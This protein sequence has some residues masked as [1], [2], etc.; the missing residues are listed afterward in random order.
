[1]L[2]FYVFFMNYDWGIDQLVHVSILFMI[3]RGPDQ[4]GSHG[5][6]SFMYYFNVRILII[7][8]ETLICSP[9]RV[10]TFYIFM[11]LMNY[12]WCSYWLVHILILFI[13]MMSWSTWFS[14]K[15]KFHV[16]FN[17]KILIIYLRNFVLSLHV[18]TCYIFIFFLWIMI[19]VFISLCI[20]S[21]L[22]MIIMS[23]STW[24]SWKEKFHILF[25]EKIL[26]IF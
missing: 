10:S 16:L 7:F 22:F 23:W 12:D 17:E 15:E 13:I 25:N 6:K 1:M 18:S 21:I 4:Y 8:K 20:F 5:K 3:R 26:I 2:Y 24:L 14:R 9:L 19:D 11:F